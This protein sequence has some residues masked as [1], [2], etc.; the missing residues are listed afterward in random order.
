MPPSNWMLRWQASHRVRWSAMPAARVSIA[1]GPRQVDG[2]APNRERLP[3]DTVV[4]GAIDEGGVRCSTHSGGVGTELHGQ[5]TELSDNAKRRRGSL[6][7]RR[8]GPVGGDRSIPNPAATPAARRGNRRSRPEPQLNHFWPSSRTRQARL[9]RGPLTPSTRPCAHRCGVRPLPRGETTRHDPSR[10]Y[11]VRR[12]PD[13][14]VVDVHSPPNRPPRPY[15]AFWSVCTRPSGTLRFVGS[16]LEAHRATGT[17]F[18]KV[19][20]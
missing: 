15:G 10:S 7:P 2:H 1:L 18:T 8:G 20:R 9:S 14:P 3:G 4:E 6:R 12:R 19:H 13:R 16:G 17:V 5:T 11:P